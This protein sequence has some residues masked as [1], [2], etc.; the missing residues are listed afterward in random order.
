MHSTEEME[1][2]REGH[3]CFCSWVIQKKK[4]PAIICFIFYFYRNTESVLYRLLT[5]TSTH[6]S[7]RLK[8]NSC[9]LVRA[10][11]TF[12][13]LQKKRLQHKCE[14]LQI[15]LLTLTVP[16]VSKRISSIRQHSQHRKLNMHSSSVL[17]SLGYS[18]FLP[19]YTLALHRFYY[20]VSLPTCPKE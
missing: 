2:T 4:S 13:N 9:F 14:H 15:N 11:H 1:G 8:K 5:L 17:Y 6:V 16:F 3:Q 7:A 20:H 19:L 18:F 12:F 10:Y